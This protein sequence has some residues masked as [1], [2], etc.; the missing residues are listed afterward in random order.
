MPI[1]L[2]I[3]DNGRENLFVKTISPNT[4]CVVGG[5]MALLIEW[6][7]CHGSCRTL[8]DNNTDNV[9]PQ[10]LYEICLLATDIQVAAMLF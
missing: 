2:D 4:L 9:I 6:R 7:L 10:K 3:S 1:K 8:V 5:H